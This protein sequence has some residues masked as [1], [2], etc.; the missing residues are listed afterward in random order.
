MSNE[1]HVGEYPVGAIIELG[2]ITV[3]VEES[4]NGCK[5]CIADKKIDQCELLRKQMGACLA[6]Q[7][8]DKISIIY[9]EYTLP[10]RIRIEPEGKS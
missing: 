4:S 7:R 5:G 2:R 9:R 3:R 10:K 8:S 6:H 1:K